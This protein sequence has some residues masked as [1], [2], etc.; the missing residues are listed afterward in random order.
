MNDLEPGRGLCGLLDDLK[1]KLTPEEEAD[2]LA[3]LQEA[4]RYELEE[5]AAARHADAEWLRLYD[6]R[7]RYRGERDDWGNE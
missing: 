5:R 3:L 4:E 2:T 1:V 7:E 6:E